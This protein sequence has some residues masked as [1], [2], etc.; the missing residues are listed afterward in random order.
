MARLEALPEWVT[1]KE[2]L[3][4]L[5]VGRTTLTTLLS[6][7]GAPEPERRNARVV[8]YAR[9]EI[10]PWWRDLWHRPEAPVQPGSSRTPSAVAPASGRASGRPRKHH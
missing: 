8:L 2:L 9:D 6:A 1:R 7:P 4:A 10:A 5:L 3:D